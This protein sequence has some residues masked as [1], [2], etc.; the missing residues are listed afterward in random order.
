MEKLKIGEVSKIEVSDYPSVTIEIKEGTLNS[1]GT[2]IIL[3]NN[4]DSVLEYGTPYEIEIKK[5]DEWHKISIEGAFT[6]PLFHL[7]P[8][9]KEE[10]EI[11][12]IYLYGRLPKG[13]YRIIK[14][15]YLPDK[16]QGITL[17]KEFN[18]A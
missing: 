4:T 8:N 3:S 12:F 15:F 6:L 17:A 2:T 5:D 11:N 10:I 18:L 13:T 1:E 16:N 7:L 14:N 9:N